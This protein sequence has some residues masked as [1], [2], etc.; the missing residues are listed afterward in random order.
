MA[1]NHAD[2]TLF[3]SILFYPC[4]ATWAAVHVGAGWWSPVFFLVAC[5]LGYYYVMWSRGAFYW[6]LDRIV[7]ITSG[8]SMDD[9]AVDESPPGFWMSWIVG[10]PLMVFYLLGPWVIVFCGIVATGIA[11]VWIVALANRIF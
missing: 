10:P 11:T 1:V 6:T 9:F 4:A 3:I 7:R 5:P 2:G 8:R